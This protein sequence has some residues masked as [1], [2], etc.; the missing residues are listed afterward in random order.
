MLEKMFI[1][2]ILSFQTSKAMGLTFNRPSFVPRLIAS[3]INKK[4]EGERVD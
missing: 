1:Y 3:T 2:L 4:M